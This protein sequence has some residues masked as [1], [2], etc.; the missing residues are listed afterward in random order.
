MDLFSFPFQYPL[1]PEVFQFEVDS[2]YGNNFLSIQTKNGKQ[3]KLK[4]TV[5][6]R[7]N[8]AKSNG[9]PAIMDMK[10]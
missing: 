2:K 1:R 8:G 4:S 9:K 6:P 5:T 3:L 10:S 7:N